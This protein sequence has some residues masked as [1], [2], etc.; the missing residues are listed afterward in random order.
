MYSQ[1]HTPQHKR[2]QSITFADLD[3]D[4]RIKTISRRKQGEVSVILGKYVSVNLIFFFYY[5]FK[6]EFKPPLYLRSN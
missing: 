2:M 6:V 4:D 3:Y 1:K 5:Y